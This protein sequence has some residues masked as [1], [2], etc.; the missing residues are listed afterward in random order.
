MM[1]LRTDPGRH[2][3]VYLSIPRD[4]RAAIPGYGEQKINAAMQLGGP[5]LAIKTADALF[6]PAGQPRRRRRHGCV[7]AADRRGRR[8]RRQRA[9][10]HPLEP[11]RLPVP[12]S[13]RCSQWKGWRFH[14]GTQHM[15]G[16]RALIYSRIRENRLNPADT[17][18]S[19]GQRQQE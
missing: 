5:K 9:A 19:R 15:D 18:I 11:L 7:P 13:A 10:E 17:D 12:T 1:L 6:G 14:K 2:R 16:H 8:H 4:L 3:L